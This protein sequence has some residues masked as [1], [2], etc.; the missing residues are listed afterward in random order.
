MRRFNLALVAVAA[1][2]ASARQG[3]FSIHED[4]VAYPQVSRTPM[5]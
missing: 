3:S 1:P 2:L 5:P 4:L